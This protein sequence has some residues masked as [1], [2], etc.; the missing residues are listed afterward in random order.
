MGT[1]DVVAMRQEAEARA[2]G[3]EWWVECMWLSRIPL[4]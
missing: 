1:E 4:E 3:G 2:V